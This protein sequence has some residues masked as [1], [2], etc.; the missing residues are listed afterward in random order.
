VF[1]TFIVVATNKHV[2]TKGVRFS[3]SEKPCPPQFIIRDTYDLSL[4][5]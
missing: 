5:S 1:N 2:L 3:Y 4:A